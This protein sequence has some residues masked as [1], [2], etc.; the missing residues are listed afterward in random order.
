MGKEP[1]FSIILL[2]GPK[3]SG[4]TSVGRALARLRGGT[5]IDLDELLEK[6]T[7]KSPRVL[8]REG[9]QMFR[10]AEA[11]AL[12]SLIDTPEKFCGRPGTDGNLNLVAAAGGGLVDNDEAVYLL[13]NPPCTAKAAVRFCIVYIEVSAETAWN[14]ILRSAAGDGGLPPFLQ[15]SDPQ[16]THLA[17][18]ERRGQACKELARITIQGENKSAESI[19]ETIAGISGLDM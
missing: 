19:A 6:Q 5:F 15:T 14:R 11:D 12:K 10:K 7:G 13:K 18:H 17:L 16:A 8:Y 4:K 3:H 1:F 9:P 2:T